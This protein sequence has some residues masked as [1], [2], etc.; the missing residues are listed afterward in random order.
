MLIDFGTKPAGDMIDELKIDGKT[1]DIKRCDYND[2]DRDETNITK[3]FKAVFDF[4][5]VLKG[6]RTFEGGYSEKF[7]YASE[8]MPTS[9]G[10][11][12]EMALKIK[13]KLAKA[14]AGDGDGIRVVKTKARGV[15]KG[16]NDLSDQYNAGLKDNAGK[17]PVVELDSVAKVKVKHGTVSE[18]KF[19]ISGWVDRPEDLAPLT[20]TD[21]SATTSDRPPATTA[22]A[23]EMAEDFG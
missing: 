4:E 6:W 7:V 14:C 19:K 16:L 23:E 1:G 22:P 18:P 13:V 15:M 20:P 9:P 21:G 11:D 5:H 12:W 3:A 10:P 2:G 17:L 8:P